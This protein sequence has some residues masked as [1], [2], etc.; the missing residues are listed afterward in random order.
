MSFQRPKGVSAWQLTFVRTGIGLVATA[1]GALLSIS[2]VERVRD[3]ADRV[4]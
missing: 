1:C 2:G 3:S 4:H